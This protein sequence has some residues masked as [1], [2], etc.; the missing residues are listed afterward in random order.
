M[1][2]NSDPL[3]QAEL[4]KTWRRTWLCSIGEFANYAAQRR[5]WLDVDESKLHHSFEEYLCCYLDGAL[6]FPGTP[7]YPDL[8]AEGLLSAQEMVVVGEFHALLS[9]Y[10]DQTD[11]PDDA[12]ILDDPAWR[13]VTQAAQR[14][15]TALAA[16]ID[17]EYEREALIGAS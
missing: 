10:V 2:E 9:A 12:T 14:A 1:N 5:L 16:M 17:D 11:W 3:A 8:I 7:E 4:R 15:Q 13:E 6:M